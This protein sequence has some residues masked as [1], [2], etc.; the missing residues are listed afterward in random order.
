MP[1]R[2]V[3]SLSTDGKTFHEVLTVEN[4]VAA[5]DYTVQIRD[6]AGDITPARARYIRV[7]AENFG[8]L[9]PWHAGAG[10]EAFIFADEI[11]IR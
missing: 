11:I 2:A 7:H 4:T 3:F 5:D 8:T 6:F 9:P 1:K 10:G